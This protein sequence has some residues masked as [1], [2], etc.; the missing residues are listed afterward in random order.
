MQVR[1]IFGHIEH[2]AQHSGYDMLAKH[3]H[4]SPYRDGW[5]YRWTSKLGSR[6]LARMPARQTPWYSLEAQRREL[7]ICA[8]SALRPTGTIF[9]WLY[10]ENDLRIS[11]SWKW[12]WNNRFVG[13]FHQP[14]E[15]LDGHVADK[16]YIRGLDGAVVVAQSQAAYLRQFLP[17]Q[18]IHHVPHG[19]ATNYW[20]PNAA[21]RHPQ[22]TFLFV[23]AWLRDVAMAKATILACSSAGLPAQFRLVVPSERQAEFVGLP[24]TTVLTQIPDAELLAEYQRAH[25]LFLPLTMATA[26]NAILEA[27]AC[28]TSVIS[29]LVGGTPEY[30]TPECGN[31]VPAGDVS[32]AQAAIAWACHNRVGT[33]QQGR[34]ARARALRFDWG[35]VGMQ[36]DAVYQRIHLAT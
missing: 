4:A 26:N 12:R 33:E 8:E 9:H 35:A 7:A 10:A 20:Q 36:Q 28:G 18:K 14:P 15:V 5:L 27:M 6:R 2:H 3:V 29:T 19:V 23:G 25:A 34:A 11:P 17:E 22:P 13:S 30:V 32:A 21:D 16:S 24:N 1:L 31:L